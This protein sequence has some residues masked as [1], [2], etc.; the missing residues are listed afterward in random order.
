MKKHTTCYW[1]SDK[2]LTKACFLFRLKFHDAN[3]QNKE[4]TKPDAFTNKKNKYRL[5][6]MEK[7]ETHISSERLGR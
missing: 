2:D 5:I 6:T 3:S 4:K 7:K 1:C